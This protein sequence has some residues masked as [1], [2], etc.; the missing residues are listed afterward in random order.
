MRILTPDDIDTLVIRGYLT[1]SENDDNFSIFNNLKNYKI[2]PN[3]YMSLFRR[4]DQK[5][6]DILRRYVFLNWG[7]VVKSLGDVQMSSPS[8]ITNQ[9]MC[10]FFMN[11][12]IPHRGYFFVEI[13]YQYFFP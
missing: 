5:N 7:S 12:D 1:I 4:L 11:P 8:N 13:L 9:E 6:S 10:I 2:C 3:S